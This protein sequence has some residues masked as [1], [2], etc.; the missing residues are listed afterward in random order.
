MFQPEKNI[1]SYTQL[2]L[3]IGNTKK[4]KK[5]VEKISLCVNFLQNK[6]PE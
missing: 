5:H 3:Y 1:F 4:K 6:N 2:S